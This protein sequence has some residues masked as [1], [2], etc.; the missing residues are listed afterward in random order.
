MVNRYVIFAGDGYY[1]RAGISS[2]VGA[3]KSLEA[4]LEFAR[5]LTSNAESVC[6]NNVCDYTGLASPDW[7]QVID[8]ESLELVA[9][10]GSAHQ[11]DD[12]ALEAMISRST[13][14]PPAA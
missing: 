9:R 7:W 6:G 1:P 3:R 13:T 2:L 8:M 14:Q 4:A 5:S 11:D 10:C 12:D